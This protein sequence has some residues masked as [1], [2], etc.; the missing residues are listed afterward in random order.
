[1]PTLFILRGA[2]GSGKSTAA[3]TLR[4]FTHIE[5][6]QYFM[7]DGKYEF[8]RSALRDAHH[9]CKHRVIEAMNIRRNVVVSNTFTKI[10]EILPYIEAAEEYGY[11][12]VVAH[13]VGRFD[14]LHGV[15]NDVVRRMIDNYEPYDGEMKVNPET[16]K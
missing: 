11:T 5:A 13:C 7:V 9:W 8:S 16:V 15:P 4:N 2:P 6:D 3:K 10:W 12:V 14:N 1:M